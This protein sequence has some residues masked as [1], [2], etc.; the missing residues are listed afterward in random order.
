MKKVKYCFACEAKGLKNKAVIMTMVAFVKGE[1]VPLCHKCIEELRDEVNKTN[2][3]EN[4]EL[5]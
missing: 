3:E 4:G 1:R 5:L 2:I